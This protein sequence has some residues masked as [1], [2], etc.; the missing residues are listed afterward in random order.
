VDIMIEGAYA[1]SLWGRL[2]DTPRREPSGK[3]ERIVAA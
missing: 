2:I 1:H 3:G